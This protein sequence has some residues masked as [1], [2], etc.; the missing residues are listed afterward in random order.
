MY[1]CTSSDVLSNKFRWL[2]IESPFACKRGKRQNF[3]SVRTVHGLILK[4]IL[5]GVF[6]IRWYIVES[7][8]DVIA[9]SGGGGGEER[10]E[11]ER[12]ARA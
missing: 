4:D 6:F 11:W 9:S 1:A 10:G 2:T 3:L 7:T 12:E 5:E 8:L